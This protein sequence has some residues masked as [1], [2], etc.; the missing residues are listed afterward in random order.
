MDQNFF[1][2]FFKSWGRS[3]DGKH[4]NLRGRSECYATG[5]SFLLVKEVAR[6][7]EDVRTRINFS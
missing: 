4:I 5:P 6:D 1:F 7:F 3:D 2:Y